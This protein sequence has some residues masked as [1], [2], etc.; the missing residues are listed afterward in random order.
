MPLCT[1]SLCE[2][3]VLKLEL[4]EAE[5]NDELDEL[6]PN[7][8]V[9]VLEKAEPPE[10]NE[11]PLLDEPKEVWLLMELPVLLP[12]EEVDPE[13]ELDGEKEEEEENPELNDW[14]LEPKGDDPPTVS[15]GNKPEEEEEST[16]K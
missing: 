13:F 8:D 10:L 14:K 4:V 11:G 2:L 15:P 3:P 12:N 6:D 1:E 9:P 7:P 5:G 16:P